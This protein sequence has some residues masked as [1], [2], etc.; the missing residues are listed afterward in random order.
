MKTKRQRVFLDAN[1]LYAAAIEGVSRN[2]WRLDDVQ[3][4]T[5]RYVIK[6][7][8]D[9]LQRR[10][11]AVASLLRLEILTRHQIEIV[12]DEPLYPQLPEPWVL[13]DLADIPVLQGALHS[14]CEV[15]LTG[16]AECF[17]EYLGKT[18]SGLLVLRPGRFLASKGF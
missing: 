2:L 5:S 11:D 4:V 9:N 12:E 16:D 8:Q 18:T 3:L 15:L 17:G 14:G 13:P 7:V 6:E 10:Q 1:V